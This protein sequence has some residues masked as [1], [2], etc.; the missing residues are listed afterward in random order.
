MF[1]KYKIHLENLEIKKFALLLLK[2]CKIA[3]SW[4]TNERAWKTSKRS[5]T[6]K[7]NAPQVLL[8]AANEPT[9][10]K[11]R[12]KGKAIEEYPSIPCMSEELSV[13]LDQWIA[14]GVVKLYKIDSEPTVE[15]KKHS[16]FCRYHRYVHH[17]TVECRYMRRL[18]HEKLVDGTL[19]VG[20]SAQGVQRNPLPQHDRGK[21]I[22]AVVIH[23][24]D[25]EEDPMISATL[26]PAAIKT[27]QRSLTF[28]SLFIGINP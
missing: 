18:F 2:A 28:R 16:R 3:A 1:S 23:A 6:D 20:R 21:G 25:E 26:T 22:V 27:L 17:P 19:E 10:K 7:R 12:K 11:K 8:V 5:K 15:N 9:S 14:E 4:K 13:I 24:G